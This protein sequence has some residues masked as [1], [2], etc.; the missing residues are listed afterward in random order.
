[1]HILGWTLSTINRASHSQSKSANPKFTRCAR[2]LFFSIC[3]ERVK[4][5]AVGLSRL[6]DIELLDVDKVESRFEDFK[7]Q[8]KIFQAVMAADQE[9]TVKEVLGG[10]DAADPKQ[11]FEL[12]LGEVMNS[13]F[14]DQFLQLLYQLLLLPS[15]Y[16]LG[17]Q[18]W[19][20]LL[21][22]VRELKD[23]DRKRWGDSEGAKWMVNID[24]LQVNATASER[25]EL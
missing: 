3:R 25:R 9:L 1:M 19:D 11:V 17:R 10:I 2:T 6:R 21:K 12:L 23:F 16:T 20:L 5:Q 15:D 18:S 22:V 7:K 14:G 24:E 8:V 4:N 13:G